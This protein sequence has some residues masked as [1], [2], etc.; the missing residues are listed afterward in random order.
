MLSFFFTLF[1]MLENK[2]RDSELQGKPP[3]TEL[4]PAQQSASLAS[5]LGPTSEDVSVQYLTLKLARMK[6]LAF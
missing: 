1:M 3:S 4:T 2:P 6:N 5:S